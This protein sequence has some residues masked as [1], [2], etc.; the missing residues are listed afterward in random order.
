MLNSIQNQWNNKQDGHGV[1]D[2]YVIYSI[3]KLLTSLSEYMEKI[4]YE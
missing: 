3:H 2:H 4:I 1:L